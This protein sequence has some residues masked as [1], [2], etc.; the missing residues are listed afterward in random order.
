MHTQT[1]RQTD[2]QTHT[3]FSKGTSSPVPALRAS[4]PSRVRSVLLLLRLSRIASIRSVLRCS[5]FFCYVFSKLAPCR[6]FRA[7]APSR[8]RSVLHLLR[9]SRV[10]SIR[11]V[12]FSLLS[13]PFGYAP[14]PMS[15]FLSHFPTIPLL[16]RVYSSLS[17]LPLALPSETSHSRSSN[18]SHSNQIALSKYINNYG[19]IGSVA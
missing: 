16:A 7:S 3:G 15:I 11:S 1:H 5:V 2:R 4:A 14:T 12:L 8:L 19:I 9:L 6:R 10:A 17:R 13:L 18:A